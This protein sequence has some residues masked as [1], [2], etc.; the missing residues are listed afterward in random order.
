[1]TTFHRYIAEGRLYSLN[2]DTL[3]RAQLARSTDNGA[4]YLLPTPYLPLDFC[5]KH[6]LL[7]DQDQFELERVLDPSTM[8]LRPAFSDVLEIVRR[9]T[10][11][12]DGRPVVR[13]IVAIAGWE[14]SSGERMVTE[15]GVV[16]ELTFDPP[17]TLEELRAEIEQ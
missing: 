3:E 1:M 16:S 9:D 6:G 13:S 7:N 10:L 4:V 11:K 15:V 12:S 17:Q 8:N 2:T 14:A 5:Q